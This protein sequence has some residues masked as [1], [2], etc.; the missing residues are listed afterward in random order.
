M[1]AMKAVELQPLSVDEE[2]ILKPQAMEHF[3]MSVERRAFAIARAA[4]GNRDDALDIVQDAMLQLVQRYSDRALEEWKMLFYRILHNKINDVFRRRKMQNKFFGWLPGS[5][6]R[7]VENDLSDPF[8]NVAGNELE[9]PETH[10]ARGQRIGNLYAAIAALPTRQ[11]E[12]FVLRCWEG[13]STADTARIMRCTQ[14]SV[15]THYS[16]A[17]ANLRDQLEDRSHE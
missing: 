3:L 4:V 9:N 1:Q 14:G 15:K 13:A 11:R 7:E 16:R 17:L 5:R 12:A 10:F 6:A 2:V 8:D